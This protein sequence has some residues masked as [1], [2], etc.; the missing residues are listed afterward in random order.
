MKNPEPSAARS[1]F[2][3]APSG[4]DDCRGPDC[5]SPG[6]DRRS[7][8]RLAGFGAATA[9]TFQPLS[10]AQ[11]NQSLNRGVRPQV[12]GLLK[13]PTWPMLRAYNRDHL[14]RLAMP[15]GGVATGCLSLMGN[16]AL[17]DWELVNRPAKGFTPVVSGAA[18]FFAVSFDD[19]EK[20]GA[21]VLEGPL[22]LGAFEG[23]HGSADPTHNLPRFANADFLAAWPLGRLELSDPG[24]PIHVALKAFSPFVPTDSEASGWPMAVLRY[25]V[26]NLSTRPM[27][28][29]VAGTL[30]N[31]VGMDGWESKRDWKGDRYPTG[32]RANRN[33]AGRRSPGAEGV[34]MD[35]E[36]VPADAEAWGSLA[37]AALGVEPDAGKLTFRSSWTDPQWGGAVL[38]FWDDFA[39][40]GML[41]ERPTSGSAP[42]ASVAHLET[43]P[44]GATQDFAFAIAWHFPNRYAWNVPE[45]GRTQEDLIGNYYTTRFTDAW[46]VVRRAAEQLPDLER[47][48]VSFISD[49]LSAS[50]PDV[51]KEAALFNASTLVTQTCF[52]TPDGNF[53]GWEGTGDSKG[54]CHGSCTHVWNYEQTS[55][56]L[57]GD[58]AARMREVEFAHAT[59]ER[60]LMS[61]RVHLP[62]SRATEF[63]K[64]AA[65]GQM[66]CIMKAYRDWQLSG[67]NAALERIWP[68]VKRALEFCW[69]EGGWDANRDGVMEGAQHNTMDVEYYGPNPQMGFWYLGALRAAEEMAKHIGD[70]AFA[71]TCR[72]L[73]EKGSAWMDA[74]LFNGEYYIHRVEP[75]D[76]PSNVAPMLLVGMGSHDLSN[77]DFQLATGCL[78]DQLVGQYMAHLCGLGYLA[79]PENI[80]ATLRAILKYNYRESLADHFNSMRSFA[81]GNEKA[82][83]MASYP[84]D[85]PTKPFP[86][87]SEVMTGFEY[88]AA[89]GMLQEGMT[90]EGITCIRNVRDR[91][92]GLKRSPFDEAE[93][94]HHYARAMAAWAAVLALTG[95]HYSAVRQEMVLSVPEGKHFFST[96]YAFGTCTVTHKGQGTEIELTV[97]EGTLPLHAIRINNARLVRGEKPPMRA[98]ET[99]KASEGTT[100]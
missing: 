83:L 70:A 100:A 92:D 88:T 50:L 26:T 95:F 73:Y 53:F 48:T 82:L 71:S 12:T 5:C 14:D 69:I 68:S 10:A 46:D 38:D 25:Q 17:R 51:V 1:P 20:R 61:F 76:D 16:G 97:R 64:P 57:F 9:A 41:D 99:W 33:E 24:L 36:G 72:G 98:G 66:G 28:V 31:F 34:F 21:R 60:G 40:D 58:L 13:D 6:V 8:F 56:H 42:V 84:K 65:D 15:I 7:F 79:K 47:R 27:R 93:C 37:L 19:G 81:L 39:A 59:D 32:A 75:P 45:E 77:P 74:N 86:Y 43:I 63:G 49:F 87:W 55:S 85:R 90:K 52:R 91:Y 94:G 29:S 35:S 78:V 44:A 96:G 2:P 89:V 80:R 67:D 30:P 3:I 22:P 18:P 23:S 62:L 4:K 54:C 11:L